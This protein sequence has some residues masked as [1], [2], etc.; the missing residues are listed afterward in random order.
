MSPSG[1]LIAWAS[2]RN[3]LN[4]QGGVHVHNSLEKRKDM[5]RLKVSHACTNTKNA[6]CM[7]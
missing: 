5:A 3:V 2:E 1:Q 6:Y 7:E 4:F